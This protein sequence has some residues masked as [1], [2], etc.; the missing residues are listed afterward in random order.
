M[1]VKH[2][3][4][5]RWRLMRLRIK[6]RLPT[7]IFLAVLCG[8]IVAVFY[9]MGYAGGYFRTTGVIERHSVEESFNCFLLTAAF[10]FLFL[11]LW[12]F[13]GVDE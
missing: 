6:R 2:S 4:R 1:T 10:I 8:G 9:W 7:A 13:R 3:F 12:P 11:T 5:A